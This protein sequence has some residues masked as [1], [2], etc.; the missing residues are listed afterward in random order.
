MCDASCH[1]SQ[2]LGLQGTIQNA[3]LINQKLKNERPYCTFAYDICPPPQK[4][5]VN[6]V[7]KNHV[8]KCVRFHY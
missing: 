1:L 3:T 7:G 5:R 4:K 2:T 8:T 6:H